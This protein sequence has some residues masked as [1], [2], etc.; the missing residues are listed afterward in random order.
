VGS[1]D[2]AG[3]YD[4]TEVLE[5]EFET[6]ENIGTEKGKL[7]SGGSR[8]LRDRVECDKASVRKGGR[9]RCSS[10]EEDDEENAGDSDGRA[11]A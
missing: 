8:W 5:D 4:G 3:K 6:V 11:L 7:G 10:D 1:R 9:V 2:A